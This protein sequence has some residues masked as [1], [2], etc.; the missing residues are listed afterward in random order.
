[1]IETT[2]QT[3][4]SAQWLFRYA[5]GVVVC[6][7]GLIGIGGL[8]T[9]RGVGMAVPDW[10]TTY[11]YNMFFFPFRLWEGGIFHEHVHR[12][13]A[14]GVGLLTVAL[15]LGVQWVER[16]S[17]VKKLAWGALALVIA[18]GVLGGTRVLLNSVPVFGIP[19]SIFFGVVHAVTAQAFLCLLGVI[20]LVLAP[21]WRRGA[22]ALPKLTI[23]WVPVL[24]GLILVQLMVAA[25]MR[26]QHA[27][28]AIPDFPLAH[29]RL[30]P[31][32]DPDF[33][34]ALNQQRMEVVDYAPITAF[35]I[36]AQMLHRILAVVIVAGVWALGWRML[37]SGGPS[38]CW[39]TIWSGLLLVQFGLGAAT[40]WTNKAADLATAHV[41]VGALSLLT[42]AL[43]STVAWRAKGLIRRDISCRAPGTFLKPLPVGAGGP[44]ATWPPTR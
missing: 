21:G 25:T 17:W 7:L 22:V 20:A 6:T 43:F 31:P 14:S 42:G 39:G 44:V 12:L 38:A 5:I 36:H 18:Q 41:V 15:A 2:N 27:G 40:I 32:T 4:R 34:A 1:M 29:G 19:G 24:T 28:L 16:R 13:V 37:R 9:S 33:I 30:Y 23:P 8:V 26:H 35:Q 3:S 11:G 10:P